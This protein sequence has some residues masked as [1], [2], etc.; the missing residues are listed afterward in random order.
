MCVLCKGTTHAVVCMSW[1]GLDCMLDRMLFL[2]A[3]PYDARAFHI[4]L[5]LPHSLQ[6]FVEPEHICRMTDGSS[7]QATARI[8]Y[9]ENNHQLMENCSDSLNN[10]QW[11]PEQVPRGPL[12]LSTGSCLN[13]PRSS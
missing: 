9:Y 7:L 6:G 12:T 8:V 2:N 5:H 13:A 10:G 4:V 3:I 11:I 1:A